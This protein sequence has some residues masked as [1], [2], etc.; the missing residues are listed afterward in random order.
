MRETFWIL[1]VLFA[2][3]AAVMMDDQRASE[4][5]RESGARQTQTQGAYHGNV[6]G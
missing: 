6:A 1:V 3:I 5:S 4:P 2:L